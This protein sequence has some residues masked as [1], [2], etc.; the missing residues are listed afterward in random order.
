[1]EV[2]INGK[3]TPVPDGHTIAELIAGM[4]LTNKRIAI[5]VNE[6]I[7]PRS[8]YPAHTLNPGDRVEVVT[9]IGGG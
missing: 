7:V 4:D 9:A 6:E 2:H 1:M 8:A 3:P 5:E